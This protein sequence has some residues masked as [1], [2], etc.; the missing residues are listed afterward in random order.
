M[1]GLLILS[2]G[3][4]MTKKV[5]KILIVA[6][7]T[8]G[9]IMPALSIAESL[10]ALSPSLSIQLVHGPSPLEQKIY[11]T[12]PFSADIL[13]VGRLRKNVPK[14]ER[15]KT[16][17]SL[18]FLLLK[19]FKILIKAKPTLVLGTGGAVSGPILLAGVLLRKKVILFEPNTVPGLS[20]RW[21]APFVHE[22]L[23]VF[24]SAKKHFRIP[25]DKL[26]KNI[27]IV[28]F[29]VRPAIARVPPREKPSQST[30]KVLI[31]GGS[32]GSSLINKVVSDL[33]SSFAEK[34]S[35][36]AT[37]FSFVHQTG[38]KEF[39]Y[40]KKVYR[41]FI[42]KTAS[43]PAS[44]AL[45][46]SPHSYPVNS[47][48]RYVRVYPFL[49]EIDQ[50]YKWSDVVL[51]RAGAGFLAEL[52]SAHRAGI[53]VPLTNSADQHQLKNARFLENQSSALVIEEENF[54]RESLKKI[55]MKLQQNGEQVTQLSSQLHKLKLGAPAEGIA[56]YLLNKYLNRSPFRA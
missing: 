43:S 33:I 14:K 30:L 4:I 29:P 56:S 36:Y 34:E 52:S 12:Y 18:P 7:G 54:N 40:Y 11:A 53:L 26:S 9:H 45:G 46:P 13:P 20:N 1:R 44:V 23:L 31:L 16:L 35:G 38:L 21:L 8:G 6:G 55:F 24:E 2:N 47:Q 27:K 22:I 51:G 19:S 37:F 50:F 15:I 28:P 48:S 17:I 41:H 25:S 10:K 39:E 42:K 49:N 5:K 3:F 32:Q